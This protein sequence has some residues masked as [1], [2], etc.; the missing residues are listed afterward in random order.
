MLYR[1]FLLIAYCV[2]ASLAA[3]AVLL[4]GGG[5]SI[6][7]V[8]GHPVD[9]SDGWPAGVGELLNDPAR[10]SGWNPWFTEWPND[11]NHYAFDVGSVEDLNRLVEKLASIDS[12]VRQIR[13]S[14]LNEPK[15][16]G[17]VTRLPEGNNIPVIFSIG[18]QSL[19]DEWYERVRK[20]FGR[21]EF[22]ATPIAVPPTLTIFVRN[23]SVDLHG[24]KVPEGIMVES[25]YVP[26]VFHRFNTTAEQERERDA[27]RQENVAT[28]RSPVQENIDPASQKA[29]EEIEAFLKNNGVYDN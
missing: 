10:T 22:I 6:V 23:D 3:P 27:V 12:E 17:W 7:A 2:V 24:L 26:A 8:K 18:D 20:P 21:M 19:I 29:A 9:V 11:L 4:G 15:G 16:L 13:L 25:G 5:T 1:R 28:G 14:Y